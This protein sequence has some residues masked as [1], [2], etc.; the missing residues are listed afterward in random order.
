MYVNNI[1]ID[2]PLKKTGFQKKKGTKPHFKKIENRNTN[3]GIV[4]LITSQKLFDIR[5]Q[6]NTCS[7]KNQSKEYNFK[8]KSVINTN[9][10]REAISETQKKKSKD[11]KYAFGK[12]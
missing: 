2:R 9:R 5:K 12:I 1:C 6:L 8:N 7:N 4:K 10:F 3:H 11:C